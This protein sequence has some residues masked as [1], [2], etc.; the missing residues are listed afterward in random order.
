MREKFYYAILSNGMSRADCKIRMT[1]SLVP[2]RNLMI[3]RADGKH[4]LVRKVYLHEFR[5]DI[6]WRR[7]VRDRQ[8]RRVLRWLRKAKRKESR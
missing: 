8:H 2:R 4:R 5:N 7:I 3:I 1:R 6:K